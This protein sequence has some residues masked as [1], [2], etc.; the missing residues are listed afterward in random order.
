M[1]ERALA[2]DAE[3]TALGDPARDELAGHDGVAALLRW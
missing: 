3:V 1:L 2:T